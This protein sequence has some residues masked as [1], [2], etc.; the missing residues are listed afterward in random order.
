MTMNGTTRGR[1]R[2]PVDLHVYRIA[3]EDSLVEAIQQLQ[4]TTPSGKTP[5]PVS[6]WCTLALNRAHD[7]SGL[8]LPDSV[9]S[10]VRTIP[11]DVELQT[12]ASQ[13]RPPDIYGAYASAHMY[14]IRLEKPLAEKIN[15]HCLRLGI[16]YADYLREI[17]RYAAGVYR[18]VPAGYGIQEPAAM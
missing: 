9:V 18:P 7:H 16:S 12:F 17:L 15:P 13:L 2:R 5:M 10:V 8:W 3:L 14:T 6:R 1:P 11:R 4:P